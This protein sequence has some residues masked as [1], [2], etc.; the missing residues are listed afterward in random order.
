MKLK[1]ILKGIDYELLQGDMEIN[2]KDISYDSRKIEKDYAFVCLIGIDTDGHNYIEK[3][4]E[5]GANCIIVCK[6]VKIKNKEVTVIKIED[7]RKQLSYLSANLFDNPQE[8]LIK[9]VRNA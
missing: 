8:K 3:A 4:I 5:N 9:I 6:N 1:K 7:T 2:I